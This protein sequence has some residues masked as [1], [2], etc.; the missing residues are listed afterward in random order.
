MF[1]PFG[2]RRQGRSEATI[3]MMAY[4]ILGDITDVAFAF[5]DDETAKHYRKEANKRAQE[6]QKERRKNATV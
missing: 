5:P 4:A 3:S 6:I 1:N 2:Q